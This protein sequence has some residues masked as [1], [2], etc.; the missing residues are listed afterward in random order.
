MK[1]AVVSI[2]SEGFGMTEALA[3]TETLGEKQ[4]LDKKQALHLRLLAEE[5][6]GM[7]RSIAGKIEADYWI[8]AEE[9]KFELH[10][11]SEVRLT[12]EMR[13]QVI[14]ASTSGKNDAARGFTGRIKVMIA[15]IILS[16]KENLPYAIIN[17]VSAMG[18]NAGGSSAVWSMSSYKDEIMKHAGESEEASLAWDELEKSIMANVADEIKVSIIGKTAEITVQKTF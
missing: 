10:M 8:E 16:A 17:T 14:S 11:K 5:L 3:M 9:T 7:I 2:T 18:G 1:S 4:S 12:P 15:N 6:L 13:E